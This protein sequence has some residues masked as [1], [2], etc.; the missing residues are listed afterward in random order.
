[1]RSLEKT[2][3]EVYAQ[4]KSGNFVIKRSK[5][6]FNQVP[7]DQATEWINKMCKS[8]G[9]IIGITRND[10]ARDR[11]CVT[12]S[13][14][15]QVS[16][17]TNAL[18]GIEDD[19]ETEI[20]STRND[21]TPSRI[22]ADEEQVKKLIEMFA[23]LHVFGNVEDHR[24][25]ERGGNQTPGESKLVAL[26]TKDVAFPDVAEALLSAEEKGRKVVIDNCQQRLVEKKTGFFEV[27]K[28][29][30][31]KTFSSMYK[32]SAT[33]KQSE[34][35][36]LKADRKLLQRLFNAAN[37]GR[38]V[39]IADI[40]KHELS[41]MPCSLTKTSGEMNSSAKS[42]ILSLLT[43][44]LGIE[45]PSDLPRTNEPTSVLIDG[46]AL[47]QALGKP[48]N[49]QTFGDYADVFCRAVFK[50]L[51]GSTTRVDVTFDRYLGSQSIKAPTRSKRT[52]NRRPIR[53]IIEGSHVQL[54]QVWD[55][56]IALD[57][58]KADLAHFLSTELLDK[59]Q[60]ISENHE[61]VADGGFPDPV[62]ARSSRRNVNHL[63]ANHEEA[64]TR[65]IL[66]GKDACEANFKR[67]VVVCRDTDV[68]LLLLYHLGEMDIEVWMS[69]GTARQRKNYP[70]H[71]IAK[72]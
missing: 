37:A 17:D 33:G 68:L 22:K 50:H 59:A 13:V 4:F 31:W 35:K 40:L 66:H 48:K 43:H 18:F 72:N 30:N 26:A 45:T 5:N 11:F 42:D 55:Q 21:S 41:P 1:M 8:A 25:I 71:L 63:S 34:N 61:D 60:D 52:G 46:H 28:K 57:D 56:F 58:N 53:K 62:N 29:H 14:R 10:Q 3:P 2:A 70:I 7:P 27:M 24:E 20:V 47:I 49:C 23:S 15:S 12:W 38:S 39:Q 32:A 69:S 64:D 16:E 19:E 9:G 36:L 6:Y 51:G 65:L 67:M 44:D 54:P